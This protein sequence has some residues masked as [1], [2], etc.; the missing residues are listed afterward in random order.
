MAQR[1]L[2]DSLVMCSTPVLYFIYKMYY[3]NNT[4]TIYINSFYTHF[5]RILSI[6]ITSLFDL[7]LS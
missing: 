7:Q 4:I 1:R 2:I 3:F 6:C 5:F